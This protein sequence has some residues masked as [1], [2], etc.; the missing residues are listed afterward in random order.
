MNKEQRKGY[1]MRKPGAEWGSLA[2]RKDLLERIK[3]AAAEKGIGAA[4]L[5][6]QILSTHF[7]PQK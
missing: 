6:D 4:F 7:P 3:K 2:I 5:A 1:A